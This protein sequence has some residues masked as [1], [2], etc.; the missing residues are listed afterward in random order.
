MCNIIVNIIPFSLNYPAQPPKRWNKIVRFRKGWWPNQATLFIYQCE[1]GRAL[2]YALRAFDLACVLSQYVH[3]HPRNTT[4]HSCVFRYVVVLLSWLP[5]PPRGPL[6]RVCNRGWRPFPSTSW[7]F[8]VINL[9]ARRP[10]SQGLC[11]IHLIAPI[12]YLNKYFT[13]RY[14][15]M[16]C[17]CDHGDSFF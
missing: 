7:C 13:I 14:N 12:R 17:L 1:R 10:S 15:A 4:I 5:L 11:M 9:W 16:L 6:Q 3:A 8:W 2:A